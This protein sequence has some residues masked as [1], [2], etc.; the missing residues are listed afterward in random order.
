M[1][2]ILCIVSFLLR[3]CSN[4]VLAQQKVVAEAT[5]VYSLE[6]TDE[7]GNALPSKALQGSSKTLYIKGKDARAELASPGFLHV[8]IANNIDSTAVLL[9]EAQGNKFI[10]RFDAKRWRQQNAKYLD[11]TYAPT[12]DS[13]VIVGYE[14]RKYI[15]TQKDGNTFSVYCAVAIT[16]S[17][18][19][20]V[21]QFANIPGFV[22]EIEQYNK[23]QKQ[24][25]RYT[26]NSF[27]LS[28]V[29]TSKFEVPTKGY[30]EL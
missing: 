8:T 7:N 28:P 10:T 19:E 6:I 29:T 15:A 20:N 23:E 30:R 11:I 2:K 13:K 5:V 17:A 3:A 25:V 9:R 22:L 24:Y 21:F 4:D 12:N 18:V 16:P 1:H 27:S 14:C 26:A